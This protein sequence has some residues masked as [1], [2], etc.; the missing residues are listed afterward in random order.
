MREVVVASS[1]KLMSDCVGIADEL[2]YMTK[3]ERD[4]DK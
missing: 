4:E 1:G 3:F 2:A